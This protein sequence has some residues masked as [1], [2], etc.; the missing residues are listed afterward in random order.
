MNDQFM[1]ELSKNLKTARENRERHVQEHEETM[2]YLHKVTDNPFT[3]DN[4]YTGTP[5]TFEDANQQQEQA[6]YAKT[7]QSRKN[8]EA[9]V[10]RV[11]Q[12]IIEKQRAER[13]PETKKESKKRKSNNFEVAK[14]MNIERKEKEIE[15]LEIESKVCFDN[16]IKHLYFLNNNL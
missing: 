13:I 11:G 12:K 4:I 10:Q 2:K 14:Q 16:L 8:L 6:L 5:D 9:L 15:L 7:P 1:S 3:M